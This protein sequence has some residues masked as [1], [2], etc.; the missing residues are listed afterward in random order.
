MITLEFITPFDIPVRD[1]YTYVLAQVDG[2]I[3]YIGDNGLVTR[4]TTERM[5]T[6][7]F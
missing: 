6:R 2:W 4:G 3:D 5:I 7:I 1:D